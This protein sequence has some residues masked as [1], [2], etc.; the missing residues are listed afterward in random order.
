MNIEDAKFPWLA[1]EKALIREAIGGANT[2]SYLPR[3]TTDRMTD[4]ITEI[5]GSIKS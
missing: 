2:S 3:R 4:S 5:E 1:P